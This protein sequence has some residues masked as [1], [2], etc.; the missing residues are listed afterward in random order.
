VAAFWIA[1][2]FAIIFTCV[3]VRA[4]WDYSIK[5]KCY[6]VVDFYYAF[7]GFNIATDILLCVLPIP[8]LWALRMPKVQRVVLCILFSMGTL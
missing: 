2:I 6:P 8:T 1:S 3:P 4:A 7:S 5:G